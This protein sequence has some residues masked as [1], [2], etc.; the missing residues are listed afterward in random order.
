[1]SA[2]GLYNIIRGMPMVRVQ[3][4]GH[5]EWF[6]GGQG[7]LGM[8]GFAVGAMYVAFAVCCLGLLLVGDYTANTATV[9]T[10]SIVCMVLAVLIARQIVHF[11]KWKTGY[12][13]R[14]YLREKLGW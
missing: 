2:G 9:R 3:E 10:V 14:F 1:M 8:E 6:Q 11:Y 13:W 12:H 7:Q 5:V 4:N